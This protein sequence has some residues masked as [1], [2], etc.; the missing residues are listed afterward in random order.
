LRGR[1]VLE[2]PLTAFAKAEPQQELALR[3]RTI[4]IQSS[5]AR[6]SLE[7]GEVDM[8]GEVG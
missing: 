1:R 2:Q 6:L 3:H 8:G 5:R 7:V 4:S